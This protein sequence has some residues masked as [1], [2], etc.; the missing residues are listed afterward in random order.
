MTPPHVFI[1]YA[2]HDAFPASLLQFAVEALLAWTF[3]RDQARNER[4]IAQQL[5]QKVRESAAMI[6][7]CSPTTVDRGSTQ[8]MELGYADAF[9]VPI[10]I[11]L[12]HI[13]YQELRQREGVPPL[14]LSSQCSPA[15]EWRSIVDDIRRHFAEQAGS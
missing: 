12:S 7:L 10:Y 11:L 13:S 5:K 8:W 2:G 4:E 1:S 3:E 14:M 15:T 6:F 9:D